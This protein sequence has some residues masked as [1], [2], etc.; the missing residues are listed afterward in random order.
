[1]S[2]RMTNQS[3]RRRFGLPESKTASVSQVIA[4][5]AKKGLIKAD[6]HNGSSRKFARCRP[7]WA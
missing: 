5:T 4:A 7:V 2:D 6:E 3:L 1:M